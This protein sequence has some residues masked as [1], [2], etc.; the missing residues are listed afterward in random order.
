M[1]PRPRFF[2]DSIGDIHNST[3][4]LDVDGALLPDGEN[5]LSEEVKRAVHHLGESNRVFLVSNGTDAARV[6]RFAA[7]LTILVA[8]AGVPAGKPG[9]RAG[10]GVPT[11][12][13]LVVVGDKVL[14]D[15]LFARNLHARFVQVKSRRSGRE[16]PSVRLSF[17]IDKVV[18]WFL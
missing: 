13:P 8:P 4:L 10:R 7:E 6:E 17:L 16:R 3:V 1:R 12:A 5:E 11:D 2:E 14:T 15:G 18:S 9:I